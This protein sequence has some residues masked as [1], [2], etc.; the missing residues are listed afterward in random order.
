M[1]GKYEDVKVIGSSGTKGAEQ[2]C[3]ASLEIE[4]EM[5][6]LCAVLAA[7]RERKVGRELDHSQ[8]RTAN[9]S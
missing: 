6:P 3:D 1:R 4:K 2:D 7:H 5:V 8:T 9:G